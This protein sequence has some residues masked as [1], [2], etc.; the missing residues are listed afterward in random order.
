MLTLA[1]EI[2]NAFLD[3]LSSTTGHGLPQ[4]VKSS[5]LFLR[6]LWGL[7]FV[8]G[9]AACCFMIYQSVDQFLQF[10]VIT[11]TKIIKNIEITFPMITICSRYHRIHKMITECN[12]GREKIK[13]KMTNTTVGLWKC[14]QLNTGTD[15]SELFKTIGED[16]RYGYEIRINNNFS[17]EIKIAVTVNNVPVAQFDLK[18]TIYPGLRTHFVLSKTIQK[19]LGPPFSECNETVGY[20]YQNE[21][22]N[23]FNNGMSKMCGCKYPVN[24]GFDAN[25]QTKICDNALNQNSSSIILQCRKDNHIECNQI[26]YSLIR[27]DIYSDVKTTTLLF[28]YFE[29]IETVEITQTPSMTITNLVSELGGLLGKRIRKSF[30]IK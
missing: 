2:K 22:V 26:S 12:Q 19:A 1:K 25:N 18:E 23:C 14:I 17:D 29:R 11:T 3:C 13:C 16:Y 28:I 5:N 6:I 15:N 9:F 20:S 24:C 27:R 8:G 10:G 4:I 30:A 21:V 7:F